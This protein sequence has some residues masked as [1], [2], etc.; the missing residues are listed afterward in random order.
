[1]KRG[2][3]VAL[4]GAALMMCGNA[5]ADSAT[6]CTA[7]LTQQTGGSF[8][9]H[10]PYLV[11]YNFASTTPVTPTWFSADLTVTQNADQ[12]LAIKLTGIAPAG[13]PATLCQ[14]ALATQDPATGIFTAYLP[15]IAVNGMSDAAIIRQQGAGSVNFT[16]QSA[17]AKV[18]DPPPS[19][20]LECVGFN[21]ATDVIKVCAIFGNVYKG[22]DKS[23]SAS[24]LGFTSPFV[25]TTETALTD[26]PSNWGMQAYPE[27]FEVCASYPITSFGF[28]SGSLSLNT[29]GGSV[30]EPWSVTAGQTAGVT[31]SNPAACN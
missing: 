26:L 8:A 1:M 20:S 16:L 3:S 21:P 10:I 14:S 5:W 27:M 28:Y 17:S 13:G 7:T 4:A 2:L 9:F 18:S 15:D 6:P 12:S 19:G 30:S 11:P 24:P 25:S 29:P 22:E 31:G 23:A